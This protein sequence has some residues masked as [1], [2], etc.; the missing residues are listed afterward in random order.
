M[1][2]PPYLIK[3][4]HLYSGFGSLVSCLRLPAEGG[5]RGSMGQ[6]GGS[7]LCV[8]GALVCTLLLWGSWQ[9]LTQFL[10]PFQLGFPMLEMCRVRQEA[11][12]ASPSHKAI[13]I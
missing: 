12:W 13:E 2:I 1:L 3:G 6:N 10:V 7:S 9:P 5:G 8:E 4:I 11:P